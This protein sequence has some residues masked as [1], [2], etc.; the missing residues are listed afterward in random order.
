MTDNV[1]KRLEQV[2][3]TFDQQAMS[4]I[5][6]ETFKA[7]TPVRTGNARAHTTLSGNKIVADYAYALPLDNGK[8]K[9]SPQGM[10]VPTIQVL[11]EHI[12]RALGVDV[13]RGAISS[14]ITNNHSITPSQQAAL[15]Q[16]YRQTN[17]NQF[18]RNNI[19]VKI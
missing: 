16:A 7:Y 8:S 6:Y 1:S 17:T 18:V 14:I 3:K 11:R 12:K 19:P 10:T 9:K 4:R 5:A 15:T 13:N 2:M